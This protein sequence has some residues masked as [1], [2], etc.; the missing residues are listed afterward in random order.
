MFNNYLLPTIY[1][2]IVYFI[3]NLIT[4]NYIPEF[5]HTYIIFLKNFKN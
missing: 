4:Y 2:Y 3:K 5:I 1:F